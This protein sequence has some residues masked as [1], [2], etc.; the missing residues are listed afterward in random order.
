MDSSER[1][2]WDA[3]HRPI[4]Y[5]LGMPFDSVPVIF[6][7]LPVTFVVFFMRGVL[8]DLPEC[9]RARRSGAGPLRV[10]TTLGPR[11]VGR[12]AKPAKPPCER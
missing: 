11:N 2:F 12:G 5:S 6:A 9:A 4:R 10:G 7:F 3:G 1:H 8:M